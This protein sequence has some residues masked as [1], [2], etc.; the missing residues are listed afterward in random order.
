MS[1]DLD[2]ADYLLGELTPAE[3][4]EAE[5]RLAED[6]AFAREVERLRPIM[7]G[8]EAL[9]GELRAAAPPIIARELAGTPTAH[10]KALVE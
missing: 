2:P 9:P 6:P 4:A 8:L 10:K 5:R 7:F 3:R 1:G